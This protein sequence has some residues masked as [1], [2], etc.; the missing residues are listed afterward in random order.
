M[1]A[2]LIPV[3]AG[4]TEEERRLREEL[5]RLGAK[6]IHI[7]DSAIALRTAPQEAQRMRH[8][9]RSSIQTGCLQGMAALATKQEP[10]HKN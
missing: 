6:M 5:D 7:L 4:E 1:T 10:P 9:A 2:S 8:M 3:R